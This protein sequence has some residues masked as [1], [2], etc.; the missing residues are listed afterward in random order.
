M[1]IIIIIHQDRG[2]LYYCL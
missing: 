1:E 2:G